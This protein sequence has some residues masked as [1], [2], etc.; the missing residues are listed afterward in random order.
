MMGVATDDEIKEAVI[1]QDEVA[2]LESSSCRM[3]GS[4]VTAV[5]WTMQVAEDPVG[6]TT[7]L[8]H[9]RVEPASP[10]PADWH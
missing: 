9:A 3:R 4:A 2:W 8:S 5:D 10:P 7:N 6:T 1:T